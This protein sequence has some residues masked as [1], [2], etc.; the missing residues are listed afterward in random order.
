MKA[1]YLTGFLALSLCVLP[2]LASAT[3]ITFNWTGTVDRVDSGFDPGVTVGQILGISLTLDG[4][5]IDE[6]SSADRGSYNA[7]PGTS[8]LVLSVNIG[9]DTSVGSFQSVT[10]LA[11]VGGIDSIEI[12]SSSQRT[13]LGFD[14]LFQT[15]NAGVV[16]SDTIPL[17]ID[18]SDFS[19]A[20][21]SVDRFPALAM[22]LPSFG[23]TITA[24]PV[25]VPEPGSLFLLMAGLLGLASIRTR[26]S[27]HRWC[28]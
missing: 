10:V 27:A 21:F 11:G 1:I 28:R 12:S 5:F 25:P 7:N 22:F 2:G 18:P 13:G 4:S 16:A 9:G 24:A 6:D 23:G 15:D 14:I 26:G 19:T 8:P 20:T 3:P 17:S